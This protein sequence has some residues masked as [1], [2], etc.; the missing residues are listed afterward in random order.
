MENDVMVDIETLGTGPDA[1]ILS[2]GACTMD[3]EKTFYKVI[4]PGQ[5]RKI[6]LD[7]ERQQ[8]GIIRSCADDVCTVL[9][10]HELL[11]VVL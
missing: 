1:Y 5:L 6:D 8:G 4:G 10:D 9:R 7:I 11:Y 2:I 3:G